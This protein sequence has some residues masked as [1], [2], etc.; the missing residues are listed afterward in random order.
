METNNNAASR[1][2]G[3][4]VFLVEDDADMQRALKDYLAVHGYE[5]TVS[6]DGE[7]AV[8][9]LR[10]D[11]RFDI[12][13]LDVMLPKKN[14]FEIL[15]E[16]R[17]MGI[18]TPV[19]MLTA[20]NGH[21]D[22]VNGFSLGADDYVPKPFSADVLEARMRAILSRTKSPAEKP[23]DV[24]RFGEIEVNFSSNQAFRSG[25]PISFTALE[26]EL[27]RY[28]LTRKGQL[29]SRTELL[30]DVWSLPDTIDTRTVDRHIASLRKKIE[31]NRDEPRHILTIYG[32]GYR[33]QM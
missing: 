33:F 6:M 32:R 16:A 20:K 19:I 13:L 27:L 14:G 3:Y 26:F 8:A 24:H 10:G 31:P 30:R 28:L 4:K 1:K 2:H 11:G 25:E 29:V 23:M 17:K 7:H 9:T 12:I 22:V 5:T 15:R 21:S 18:K